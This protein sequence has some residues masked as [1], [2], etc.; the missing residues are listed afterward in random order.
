VVLY[1]L[2]AILGIELRALARQGLY[3][4]SHTLSLLCFWFVFQV[5]FGLRQPQAGQPSFYLPN[6][7]QVDGITGFFLSFFF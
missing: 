2:L 3:N 5:G 7:S 1:C 4:L 6:A